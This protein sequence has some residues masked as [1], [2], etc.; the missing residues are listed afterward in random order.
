MGEKL[1]AG[2]PGPITSAS[3]GKSQSMSQPLP[4]EPSSSSFRPKGKTFQ[5]RAEGWLKAIFCQQ[6]EIK[7]EQKKLERRVNYCVN[8]AEQQSG[9]KYTSDHS[10][11]ETPVFNPGGDEGEE[12]SEYGESEDE[13][14]GGGAH[15]SEDDE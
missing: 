12:S 9:T 8:V 6:V 15:E 5:Q 13:G 14:E 1:T 10:D 4:A 3:V 2:K 7:Q 11:D